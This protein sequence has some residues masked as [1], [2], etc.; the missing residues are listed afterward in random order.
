MITTITG[1]TSSVANDAAVTKGSILY[2]E[3][4]CGVVSGAA[5]CP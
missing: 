4:K 1:A 3:N 2:L 5:S